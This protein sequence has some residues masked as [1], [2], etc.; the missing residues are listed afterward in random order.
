MLLRIDCPKNLLPIAHTRPSPLLA[1]SVPSLSIRRRHAFFSFLMRVYNL[2]LTEPNS[3]THHAVSHC[4]D[5]LLAGVRGPSYSIYRECLRGLYH[6]G[7]LNHWSPLSR[8]MG[9]NAPYL[10]HEKT[11]TDASQLSGDDFFE[12][13]SSFVLE[14]D[15]M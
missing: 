13:I 15:A 3:N 1:T 10:S 11:D 5:H 7:R 2:K 14:S 9:L 12:C 6:S 4:R 8:E